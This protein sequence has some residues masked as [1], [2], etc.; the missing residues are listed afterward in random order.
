LMVAAAPEGRV[1]ETIATLG[2]LNQAVGFTANVVVAASTPILY[3][4]IKKPLW[5]AY[6]VAGFLTLLGGIPVRR[7]AADDVRRTVAS[8]PDDSSNTT[9]SQ[10]REGA[11]SISHVGPEAPDN[12]STIACV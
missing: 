9:A 11:V 8:S 4:H 10:E 1:G 5:I 3:A 12:N 6:L 2:M 7:L